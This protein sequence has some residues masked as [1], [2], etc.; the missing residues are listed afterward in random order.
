MALYT[1]NAAGFLVALA[2]YAFAAPGATG[3]PW[4][5]WLVLFVGQAF[6]LARLWVKLQF[7]ASQ[8]AFFQ[9]TLAHAGYVAAPDAKWPESPAVEA[10]RTV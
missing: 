3:G 6:I 7:Y 2:L 8:T 5:T 9:G 10:V 1:L 4:H